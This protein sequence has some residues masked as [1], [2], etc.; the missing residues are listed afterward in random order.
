[1]EELHPPMLQLPSTSAISP[2]LMAW[3]DPWASQWGGDIDV[4]FTR[5]ILVCWPP[6]FLR[7][8]FRLQDIHEG[9]SSIF[10]DFPDDMLILLVGS[11]KRCVLP[12]KGGWERLPSMRFPRTQN[13]RN[14]LPMSFALSCLIQPNMDGMDLVE[15]SISSHLWNQTGF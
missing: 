7:S 4:Y 3:Y 12:C 8:V 11:S 5:H 2:P 13:Q 9:V 14:W 10:R 1:M 15:G 6:H